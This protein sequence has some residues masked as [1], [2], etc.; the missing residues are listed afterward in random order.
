MITPTLPEVLRTAL[1]SWQRDLHTALPGKVKSYDAA[2]QTAEV[3]PLIKQATPRKDGGI[4]ENAIPVIPNVRVLWPRAGGFYIH[5]PMAA[6][7]YVLLV[8]NE[9][10]IG[11]WRAGGGTPSPAGDLTRHGLSHPY[12]IPGGWPDQ[13]AFSD[14][15]GDHGLIAVA[16]GQYLRVTQAGAESEEGDFVA[17]KSAF[18]ALQA[19]FDAHVHPTGVGPS[20]TTTPVG[21]QPSSTTLK[22]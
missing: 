22:A 10:A 13:D 9:A 20:G 14:A 12:A 4:E 8:F 21:P 5:F 15:P 2:T 7:D 17:L 19:A 6:G 1:E 16:P 11:H 18:D 3:I